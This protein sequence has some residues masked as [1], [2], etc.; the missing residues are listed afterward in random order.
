MTVSLDTGSPF[1]RTAE[2]AA[3]VGLAKSTMEKLRIA[4]GGPAYSALGRVI[5]YE[6]HDLDDWVRARKQSS[7]SSV[8]LIS[9]E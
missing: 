7:T 8:R 9:S 5:V 1:V 2:A 4:G 3:Y 6:I